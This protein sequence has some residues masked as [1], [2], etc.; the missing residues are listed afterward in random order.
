MT[1]LQ[2]RLTL[3]P[4]MCAEFGGTMED[5]LKTASDASP[6]VIEGMSGYA[7]ALSSRAGA[8]K[9]IRAQLAEYDANIIAHS[10]RLGMTA[11]NNRTWKPHQYLALLFTE[12]YLRRYF[13]DA[14]KLLEDLQAAKHA[15]L[16]DYTPDDLRTVALQSA[17][18]SGK[19]LLMHANILQYRHY[20][21]RAEKRLNNTLLLTPNEQMS[22]QH[23]RE[24]GG[25]GLS[26]RIFS[27]DA[28]AD[29]TDPV[30]ILHIQRL[31]EKSGKTKVAA[32]EFGD[33]NLLLVDEGHLGADG[34][35]WREHRKE[36]ARGG[37]T[38]EYSATFN[39]IAEKHRDMLDSYGKCV[40]FDYSYSRFH[41]DG[42]GKD[43][44]ITNLPHG[45]RDDNSNMYLLGCLLTFYQQ[46][47]I[48]E[49][50]GA[51]W[52]EYQLAKPLW[53]FLGKTV[54]GRKKKKLTQ[55]DLVTQSDIVDILVFL[56]WAL[57]RGGEVRKMLDKLLAGKSGLE[58]DAGGDYF[59]NRFAWLKEN[60]ADDLY[61]DLCDTLFHGRGKLHVVYLTAGEGEMHLRCADK[62]VFGL[63][64]IGES[65]AL[66]KK[67]LQDAHPDLTIERDAGFAERMFAKVDERNSSV[68]IVIGARRF[69]AGWNSWRVS[70]MGLLN[71]GR[72]AGPEVV[73][74]FGRGVR[75]K[76]RGMCLKRHSAIGD[77]PPNSEQLAELEKLHIFGLRADYMRTFR[78]L[79]AKEGMHV[80]KETIFL[81][82]TRNFGRGE[83]L[84]M[85]GL[86]RDFSRKFS[87]ERLELPEPGEGAVVRR[88]LYSVLQVAEENAATGESAPDKSHEP[89]SHRAFFNADRICE[90][91][92]RRKQHKN[93]H[94]MVITRH[95]VEQLLANDNWYTLYTPPD[96]KNPS[97]FA[98]V[99]EQESLAVEMIAE[100]AEKFWR[101]SRQKLAHDNAEVYAVGEDDANYV[102][103]YQVSA[104]A[105][106]ARLIA[107]LRE[108]KQN[109]KQAGFR[110][111]LKLG[112]IRS[113]AHGYVP[114]L[115]VRKE[116][117]KV[118]VQPV[119]LNESEKRV[120]DELTQ[121]AEKKDDCLQGRDVFL[122]R[123]LSR[124]HGVS[125]FGGDKAAYYP[126][127]IVW[128]KNKQD[129]HVLVLDSKGLGIMDTAKWGKIGL[130]HSIKDVEKRVRKTDK[131]IF[132]HA[133]ILSV[134]P[135]DKI[136]G[137][138]R[139]FA[140]WKKDGVYFKESPGAL[141]EIIQDALG[142]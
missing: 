97:T 57:A 74:M 56:G 43:H 130:H 115:Y 29:V 95:A 127:F 6:D 106:D 81:P 118:T 84:K 71:V 28:G 65:D 27:R 39:Q 92:L 13:E 73:Q 139:S 4:L 64:N 126:D 37:F 45:M 52:S 36:L 133:Y 82:T 18:G 142:G 16:T 23:E 100:Y 125:F 110:D 138:R 90:K 59:A 104:D 131:D 48:W 136:D 60:A 123:N 40:L 69:I 5:L 9:N 38:F 10:R 121:L 1:A 80:E 11:E 14:D 33:D 19:T 119:P 55:E 85:L 140:E 83:G 47:R 44:A 94:N 77:A 62:R 79:L 122:I 141:R 86:P 50:H 70:T 114:L 93:W 22:A 49:M 132:L 137:G 87:K 134:T 88:D 54:L 124:G 67:L 107:D 108:L 35:V 42:Y 31:A 58:S 61:G 116:Q 34:N 113:K 25:S 30:E 129:Q 89:F 15:A 66:Y 78:D 91:L 26:A 12:H 46:C 53:M 3:Q 101:K 51:E 24:M 20:I 76:G 109:I 75:L 63:V 112:V 117:C 128:L 96:K 102:R 32:G 72:S 120:V 8:N 105:G 21:G 111:A 98:Q 103:E 41:A 7:R 99:R 2:N 135:R 68:N 17:T